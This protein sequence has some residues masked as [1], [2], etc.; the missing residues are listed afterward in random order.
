MKEIERARLTMADESQLILTDLHVYEHKKDGFSG[1][2][3]VVLSRKAITDVRIA[4]ERS[5]AAIGFSIFFGLVWLFFSIGYVAF[6]NSQ[7]LE[8]LFSSRLGFLIR[9]GSLVV[10][11]IALLVYFFSKSSQIQIHTPTAKVGGIAKDYQQAQN[12]CDLLLSEQPRNSF[13]ETGVHDDGS[14]DGA[15]RS[16]I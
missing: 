13:S 14:P 15:A 8:G 12:F 7:F 16:I 9:N 10:V 1:G 6:G 4:W 3:K 11:V 5:Q 2:S